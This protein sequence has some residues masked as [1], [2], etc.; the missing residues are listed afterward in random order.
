MHILPQGRPSAG[1]YRRRI[2]I[3]ADGADARSGGD[4]QRA[5]ARRHQGMATADEGHQLLQ[6]HP[7]AH[8]GHVRQLHGQCAPVTLGLGRRAGEDHLVPLGVQRVD[9]CGEAL[10]APFHGA[11]LGEGVQHHAYAVGPQQR[12]RVLVGGWRPEATE[13]G[14]F[15][16]R[17]RVVDAQRCQQLQVQ[18]G[19]VQRASAAAETGPVGAGEP[20]PPAVRR[21]DAAGDARMLAPR[22]HGAPGKDVQHGIDVQLAQLQCGRLGTVVFQ[23]VQVQHPVQVVAMLQHRCGVAAP[24][25]G[26][27]HP[28][29]ALLEQPG[30]GQ[31]HHHVTDA[32]GA[33]QED[34]LRLLHRGP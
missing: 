34:V 31:G 17:G 15:L 33:A 29:E 10:Q 23:H 18:L 9:E 3:E 22:C 8:I 30:Q 24:E 1:V 4:V 21:A 14:Q 28:G 27:A 7:S 32:V 2:G 5:G 26:D 20:V 12:R 13:G 6:V 16:E 19:L 25:E 11:A